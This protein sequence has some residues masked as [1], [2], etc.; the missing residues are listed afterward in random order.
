VTTGQAIYRVNLATKAVK[1]LAGREDEPGHVDGVG[2]A[3]R[4]SDAEGMQISGSWLYFV[5]QNDFAEGLCA[6]IRRLNLSTLR[7]DTLAGDAFGDERCFEIDHLQAAG[8]LSSLPFSDGV[9]SNVTFGFIDAAALAGSRL[10]FSDLDYIR[11]L[12]LATRQVTTLGP[13]LTPADHDA[14]DTSEDLITGLTISGSWLYASLSDCDQI[15]KFRIPTL[16][17]TLI[18][19]DPNGGSGYVDAV[20]TAARF[21]DPEGSTIAGS[22]LFVADSYNDCVRVVNLATREVKTAL[23]P[24]TVS[25]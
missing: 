4:L 12:N 23:G 9:G 6:T 18:A 25:D 10:Y 7:V 24:C 17:S 15:R 21:D 14:C 20:G 1:L 22:R 19:G 11:V 3:A 2:A 8:A 5:E 16:E 13:A